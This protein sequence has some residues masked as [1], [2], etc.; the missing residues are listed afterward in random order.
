[1][2]STT[3]KTPPAGMTEGAEF[4]L[5]HYAKGP[6]SQWTI[7]TPPLLKPTLNH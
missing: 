2:T 1:M 3:M 7:Y 6:A 5:E 4:I